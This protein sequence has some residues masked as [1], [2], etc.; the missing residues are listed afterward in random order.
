MTLKE[1]LESGKSFR[2]VGGIVYYVPPFDINEP[3]TADQ[4]LATDWELEEEKFEVTAKEILGLFHHYCHTS[5]ANQYVPA[6]DY[7]DNLKAGKY[8]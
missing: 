1:A 7:L 6:I 2:R 3:F 8:K 5:I 4:I